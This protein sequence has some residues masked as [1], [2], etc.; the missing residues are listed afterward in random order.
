MKKKTQHNDNY[1][2]LNITQINI[3]SVIGISYHGDV[4]IKDVDDD[5]NGESSSS[6]Y[7]LSRS[8]S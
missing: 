6:L 3:S 8:Q 2:F 1:F 7:P 5:N 4:G